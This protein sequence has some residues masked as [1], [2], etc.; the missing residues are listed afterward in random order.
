[1]DRNIYLE[2][3]SVETAKERWLS[4]LNLKPK[5]KIIDVRESKGEI[6]YEDI[7][8]QMSSP[9]DH[10]SAMDGIAVVAEETAHAT[11]THPI[12]I[13]NYSFV[14][15]GDII[16]DQFNAVIKIEDLT[17]D[18]Q[19]HAE[20]FKSVAPWHNI[21]TIGESM[22]KGDLLLTKG[23]RLSSYDLG[24]LIEG[25]IQTIEVIDRPSVGILP[26]GTELI[27]IDQKFSK[28][29]IY[30]FNSHVIK[31]LAKDFGA[32]PFKNEI[33]K[34]DYTLLKNK[35]A[36]EAEQRDVVVM[37]AGTSAGSEDYTSKIIQALGEV[38]VHGVSIKPG[39]PTIL[40]KINN[41]PIIG[42]PGYPVAAAI[43]FR[44]FGQE[45]ISRLIDQPLEEPRTINAQI[46]KKI[47]SSLGHREYV[48]VKLATLENTLVAKPLK[49]K[50]GIMSSL[51]EADGIVKISEFSEG[52]D[53]KTKVDVELL[54][55]SVAP[56]NT[57]FISGSNDLTLDLLKK[58]LSRKNI[59]L[60]M[61]SSGSL[62]GLMDLRRHETHV[63]GSHLLDPKTGEYNTSYIEKYLS[64][65]ELK[66][67]NLVYRKQGFIINKN[68]KTKIK[69]IKDLVDQNL[70]Y[71]NRQKGAGTRVLFDYLLKDN[72]IDSS[73]I[74]G[75]DRVEYT[76][77]TLAAA[78]HSHSADIGLGI[79][80]AA[81]AFD[82]DFIPVKEER[83]DLVIPER[84]MED[85]RIQALLEVIH[86][87]AFQEEVKQFKGYD[88]R[89][90]G[91]V[92][93]HDAI[94]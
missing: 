32:I 82:L 8:A 37:I 62:G 40:G 79:L 28:G 84:L 69:S 26:T 25:G 5:S 45:I 87:E 38:F 36:Q 31:N 90:A 65:R 67:I 30:E 50:S 60:L 58:Y 27:D 23:R 14:D 47:V 57:L 3:V 49:R 56:E 10:T 43:V 11:E 9:N 54:K 29:K 16:P 2:N 86:N 39:G 7:Y 63:A 88:L 78:I 91:K 59:D 68:L 4:Q 74:I 12:T 35:L 42:L 52:I 17:I 1:M 76:H 21:R 51:A 19:K 46:T 77:M 15:T 48:R 61:T 41:T 64:N 70:N 44:I 22:V 75:Y 6:L 53:S 13:E 85:H 66:L 93:E 71:I 20:I 80:A 72:K 89:D 55:A 73:E 24:V 83:Y 33:I 92:I 94:D 81:Q 34:D 18:E